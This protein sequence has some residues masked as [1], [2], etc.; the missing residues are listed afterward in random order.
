MFTIKNAKPVFCA[1]VLATTFAMGVPQVRASDDGILSK[2]AE[3]DGGYCH[4]TFP[5]IRP[6]TLGTEHPQLKSPA[7]GDIID[8]YG[9]CDHDPLGKEEVESQ[10]QDQLV[11]GLRNYG[12]E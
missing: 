12:A 4:L 8:F 10:E 6:E 5:A 9:P 2:T 1:V 7:E 11:G 3:S